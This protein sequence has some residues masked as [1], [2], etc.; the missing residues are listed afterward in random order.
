MYRVL[1][2]YI[3]TPRWFTGC[4]SR[5]NAYKVSKYV[6]RELSPHEEGGFGRV[7]VPDG[8]RRGRPV[9]RPCPAK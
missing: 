2:Q 1:R 8:L 3:G 5:L 7:A 9:S 6:K 4:I